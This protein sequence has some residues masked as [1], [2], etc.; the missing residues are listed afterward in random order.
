MLQAGAAIETLTRGAE[1]ITERVTPFGTWWRYT[2]SGDEP[3]ATLVGDI[4]VAAHVARRGG[5]TFLVATSSA[6]WPDVYVFV[7]DHPDA[8]RRLHP[9]RPHPALTGFRPSHSLQERH[10][11]VKLKAA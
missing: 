8:R 4:K 2:P 3:D 9:A 1:C 6:R 5:K 11:P 10:Y 7:H